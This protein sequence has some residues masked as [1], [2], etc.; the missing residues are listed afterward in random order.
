M[1]KLNREISVYMLII[2]V[3]YGIVASLIAVNYLVLY[4]S[5]DLTDLPTIVATQQRDQGLYGG[6]AVGLAAYK[7][8]TY[9]QRRPEIVA[10]GT[11][12]ALQIRDYFFTRPFYNL[13]GMTNGQMQA[14]ALMDRLL[15]KQPPKTVI[16]AVDFWTFCTHKKEFPPFSRPT[17]SYHDGM[18]DPNKAFLLW[19]LVVEGRLSAT[20][21]EQIFRSQIDPPHRILPRTGLGSLIQDG[22]T[23]ADGSL[24]NFAAKG[25]ADSTPDIENRSR[26]EIEALSGGG[27]RIPVGC[28]VSDENLA[29]LGMLGNELADHGIRL[30]VVA[31]P[32]T[33]AMLRAIGQMPQA[34]TYMTEWRRRL[35]EAW[36]DSYDFT[37]AED[38][39]ASDCE[40]YDG[41]H[42]GE[43]AYAR[44]F[45]ALA[46]TAD[47][48]I[49]SLLNMENLNHVVSLGRD[50]ITVAL[51]F[52]D[53]V[54]AVELE[55]FR[56]CRPSVD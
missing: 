20:D 26:H 56:P 10:I 50:T 39:G 25:S 29:L 40:F 18:G 13:G 27:G 28:Q 6:L 54:R 48:D 4:R 30:I 34:N 33:S 9:K 32:V 23:G 12:R 55:G 16:F 8:E 41:I 37:D 2:L 31:P 46:G 35:K 11:S 14:F 36:P 53:K 24:F 3:A 45:R 17:G 52:P 38:L 51:G 44:L 22:G 43:V 15:L 21:L 49:A 7:Y 47:T 19:R 42:G 1:M 5:G